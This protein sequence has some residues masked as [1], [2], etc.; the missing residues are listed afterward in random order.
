[1]AVLCRAAPAWSH[2][3]YGYEDEY[4]VVHLNDTR[5]DDNYVLIYDC[6]ERPKLGFK[7]IRDIV[8]RNGGRASEVRQEWIQEHVRKWIPRRLALSR[9]KPPTPA[10]RKAI[11][12]SSSRHGL[13]PNLIYAVIEAESG[14]HQYA[15]SPKGAQG[16]MQIMPET[17]R[18]LGLRQPFD[19]E[20]NIDTGARYLR[21][22]MK[23]FPSI[24]LALA[25]Y[26]A[27]PEVVERYQGIPPYTETRQYVQRVLERYRSMGPKDIQAEQ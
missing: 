12:A 17:Q 10:I 5:L 4:G 23:R 22:L 20:Q 6:E 8:R 14:F 1:M 21:T 18:T 2:T 13:D 25:A 7:E 15:V 9:P 24:E 11:Q 19:P 3:L 26:N 16:L 27:G